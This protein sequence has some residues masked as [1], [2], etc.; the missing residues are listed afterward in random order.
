MA[1]APGVSCRG[2]GDVG[3][4]EKTMNREQACHIIGL[5]GSIAIGAACGIFHT[6]VY[7]LLGIVLPWLVSWYFV[8]PELLARNAEREKGKK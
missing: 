8:I 6:G 7:C 3:I 4:E 1:L 5:A 2:G